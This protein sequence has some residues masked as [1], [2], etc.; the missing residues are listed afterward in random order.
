MRVQEKVKV[1]YRTKKDYGKTPE[2]LAKRKQEKIQEEAQAAAEA[3]EKRQRDEMI[4]RGII[5]LPEEE[6][7]RLI[8]GLKA[9][10][11]SLNHEYMRL[12]LTVDT[13]P[14]INRQVLVLLINL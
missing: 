13:L 11:E 12:S 2:Y 9:N 3:K 5:P 8:A 10:W 7:Q 4:K 1:D 14:K 6:R